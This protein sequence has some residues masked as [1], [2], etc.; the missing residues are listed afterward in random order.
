MFGPAYVLILRFNKTSILFLFF[1]VFFLFVLT[2]FEDIISKVVAARQMYTTIEGIKPSSGSVL[3]FFKWA[4]F[5]YI[6]N[7]PII[8]ICSYKLKVSLVIL[9]TLSWKSHICFLRLFD[10]P[11]WIWIFL[12]I[13]KLVCHLRRLPEK[14]LGLLVL[15]RDE[16]FVSLF[17]CLKS[18]RN[19]QTSISNS[20]LWTLAHFFIIKLHYLTGHFASIF[21]LFLLP[22][23]IPDL[24]SNW[25]S[26]T[27]TDSI[28]HRC[29][30]IFVA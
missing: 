26:V 8:F 22:R 19:I 20:K 21:Q 25:L 16:M 27:E 15:R 9:I 11:C 3:I 13:Q 14:A 18:S 10:F 24:W 7:E 23:T 4:A 5:G 29:R 2:F 1:V 30:V 12:G 17:H 28:R 6:N